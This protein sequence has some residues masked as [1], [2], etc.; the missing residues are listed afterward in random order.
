M[1]DVRLIT[2]LGTW[3]CLAEAVPPHPILEWEWEL[4]GGKDAS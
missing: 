2:R 3:S 4:R 1:G